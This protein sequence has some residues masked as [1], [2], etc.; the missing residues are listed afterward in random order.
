[1]RTRAP[2]QSPPLGQIEAENGDCTRS[3]PAQLAEPST[4]IRAQSNTAR[5]WPSTDLQST[6]QVR[7][8]RGSRRCRSVGSERPVRLFGTRLKLPATHL[9][10]PR[11]P[12]SD[13][14][15]PSLLAAADRTSWGAHPHP[16]QKLAQCPFD[17]RPSRCR[18]V[19]R[20]PAAGWLQASPSLTTCPV[21]TR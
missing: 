21:L 1:M 6:T 10:S 18:T 8:P 13:A 15:A 17:L 3:A 19:S 5:R 12:S 9:A 4:A 7:C 20:S 16:R 14:D 11:Q 2:H